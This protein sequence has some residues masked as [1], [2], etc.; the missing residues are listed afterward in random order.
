[1][2]ARFLNHISPSHLYPDCCGETILFWH[3]FSFNIFF[4]CRQSAN[5]NHC[6][7]RWS[8]IG[9]GVGDGSVLWH[10]SFMW[11]ALKTK[12]QGKLL[13]KLFEMIFKHFSEPKQRKHL[14]N[15]DHV[16]RKC[17]RLIF[18]EYLNKNLSKQMDHKKSKD[19][20]GVGERKGEIRVTAVAMLKDR[21]NRYVVVLHTRERHWCL[22]DFFVGGG[23]D[24]CKERNRIIFL[25]PL[26]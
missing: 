14:Q 9:R 13:I 17:H 25:S 5:A 6:G 20:G 26:L 3:S 21:E 7:N 19:W 18:L 15:K 24:Q 12:F 11:V 23:W 16:M 4:Y 8:C 22:T 10:Q 1:M 2:Q